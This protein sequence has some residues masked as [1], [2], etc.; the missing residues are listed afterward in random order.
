MKDYI[1]NYKDAVRRIFSG[2]NDEEVRKEFWKRA[3][4]DIN[5]AKRKGLIK[6]RCVKND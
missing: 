1:D 3:R 2:E 6:E 5:V 4:I